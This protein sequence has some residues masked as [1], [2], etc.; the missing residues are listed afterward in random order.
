MMLKLLRTVPEEPSAR[1]H[2]FAP[3]ST[4]DSSPEDSCGTSAYVQGVSALSGVHP[5]HVLI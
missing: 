2:Y 5:K 3:T 1:H 4:S